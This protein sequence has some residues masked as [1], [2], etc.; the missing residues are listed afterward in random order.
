MQKKK[1]KKYEAK[2]EAE[3]AR[4]AAIV[5]RDVKARAKDNLARVVITEEARCKA[6]AE[7]ARLKGERISLML[8][9]GATKDEVSSFHSQAGKDKAA[10]EED[11]QK[12]LKLIFAYG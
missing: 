5:G 3:H 10:I 6:E 4:L 11:Y 9:I 12:A 7:V 8:E 2:K 1:I